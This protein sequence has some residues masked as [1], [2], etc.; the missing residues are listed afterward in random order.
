[1]CH[2]NPK[3]EAPEKVQGKLILEGHDWVKGEG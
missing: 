3:G 2:E 1:M